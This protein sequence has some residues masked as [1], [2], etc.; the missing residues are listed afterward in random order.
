L[1]I[2]V[3]ILWTLTR[4]QANKQECGFM[5][6]QSQT[7]NPIVVAVLCSHEQRS[8]I[9]LALNS[10]LDLA[11]RG[12]EEVPVIDIYVHDPSTW[13]W[14]LDPLEKANMYHLLTIVRPKVGYASAMDWIASP[15]FERYVA[16]TVIMS[17]L[18]RWADRYFAGQQFNRSF[19]AAVRAVVFGSDE[20]ATSKY[21]RRIF[22]GLFPGAAF[23]T[24][25]CLGQKLTP[26]WD[27]SPEEPED[28]ATH[29]TV[30][31]GSSLPIGGSLAERLG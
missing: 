12:G 31:G 22:E 4:K 20:F 26:V 29:L 13:L 11:V 27:E 30:M 15:R 14:W 6:E 18:H 21:A 7:Q 24:A 16:A 2:Y 5:A 10:P 1:R 8:A 23:L 25:D 19:I 28:S 9:Q 17:Q 3:H